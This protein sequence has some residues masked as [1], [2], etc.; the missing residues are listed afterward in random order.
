M[1]LESEEENINGKCHD[2]YDQL[3]CIQERE[4]DTAFERE[5][6]WYGLE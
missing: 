2:Q 3:R 4:N 1:C 5:M 6:S